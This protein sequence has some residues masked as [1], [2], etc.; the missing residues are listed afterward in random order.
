[1]G[2]LPSGPPPVGSMVVR[3]AVLLFSGTGGYR[4][5]PRAGLAYFITRVLA[6]AKITLSDDI[7]KEGHLLQLFAT[8]MSVVSY[9]RGYFFSESV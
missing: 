5:R 4:R 8:R 6:L 2:E 7:A 3:M 9:R 1:M